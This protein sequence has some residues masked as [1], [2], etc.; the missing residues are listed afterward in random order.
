MTTNNTV[1]ERVMRN[2]T[3]TDSGN[4]QENADGTWSEAVPL[5]FYGLRKQCACGKKFWKE[6]S[7][8]KHYVTKHTDGKKYFRNVSG[9]H[10]EPQNGED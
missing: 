7:Y 3:I 1:K 4:Y 2:L 10:V 6:Q 9:F 8:H 5:P